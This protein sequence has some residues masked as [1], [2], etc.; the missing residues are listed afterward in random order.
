MK[1]ILVI[2]FALL[3]VNAYSQIDFDND[4]DS[5]NDTYNKHYDYE[6]LNKDINKE[7]GVTDKYDFEFRFWIEPAPMSGRSIFILS[8]K[9]DQWNARCFTQ[10][11]KIQDQVVS[12]YWQEKELAQN[13]LVELWG[14]LRGNQILT[15][16][17]LDSIRDKMRIYS[18]DTLAVQGI[19]T[20]LSGG[21]YY[22]PYIL[23]G[24]LYRIELR[25]QDKKRSYSYHC[26]KGYLKEC[27]N[28]EELFRAYAIVCLVFRKIGWDPDNIC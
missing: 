8:K 17:T 16:P 28:V 7:F 20:N 27:P 10:K 19:Y 23:D 4:P 15:L 22:D 12:V 25:T 1:N 9:D 5:F 11:V 6:K 24:V 18:A 26:P 3:S 2:L 21:P 13:D 14:K